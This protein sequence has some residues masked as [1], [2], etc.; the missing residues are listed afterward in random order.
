VAIFVVDLASDQLTGY[1]APPLAYSA[2]QK[3][4]ILLFA[5]AM[6]LWTAR[7]SP[8]AFAFQPERKPRPTA[9]IDAALNARLQDALDAGLQLEPDGNLPRL[10]QRLG[11]PE[12]R[13]RKLINE[14]LGHR[15]FRSFL[16]ARRVE[17][18]KA[19]LADPDRSSDGV[20]AIAFDAGFA[21]LASFNRVFKEVAG[22]TPSEW[23]RKNRP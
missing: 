5:F 6:L 8:R 9:S 19:L 13:L 4:A 18:A 7:A 1:G 20:T 15:N 22:E 10:A 11:A 21:S 3:G 17:T 2:A 16:N 14:G 23:R 12:H